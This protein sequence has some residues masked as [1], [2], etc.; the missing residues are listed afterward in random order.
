MG[1]VPEL[2]L[3]FG[4]A[5]EQRASMAV[6]NVIGSNVFDALVPIGLGGVIHPL[7]VES[8]TVAL[9]FPALFVAMLVLVVFLVRCSGVRPRS[10]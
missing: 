6:G 1:L 5:S 10:S 3:S 8:R 2:A 9:D 4:A 7:S